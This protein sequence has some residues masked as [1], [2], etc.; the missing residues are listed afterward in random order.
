MDI[1]NEMMPDGVTV[2][3]LSPATNERI[4]VRVSPEIAAMTIALEKALAAAEISGAGRIIASDTTMIFPD[5]ELVGKRDGL[6]EPAYLD[7]LRKFSTA[8][9]QVTSSLTLVDFETGTVQIGEETAFLSLRNLDEELTMAEEERLSDL[10]IHNYPYLAPLTMAF[11]VTVQQVLETYF[12]AFEHMGKA[13]GHWQN[14]NGLS[15][16]QIPLKKGVI[17]RMSKKLWPDKSVSDTKLDAAQVNANEKNPDAASI[18]NTSKTGGI[19]FDPAMM[20]L[21][22][23]RDGNGIPCRD[24]RHHGGRSRDTA[25]ASSLKKS[26]PDSSAPL[27]CP[28][29]IGGKKVSGFTFK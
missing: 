9:V 10:A 6:N 11:P 22:I 18:D 25:G 23:Q 2:E 12:R 29:R 26:A 14:I 27:F 20:A 13:A 21:S 19:N 8:P 3:K 16:I 4:S 17:G 5:K 7:S 15:H 28:E 24:H 1:V